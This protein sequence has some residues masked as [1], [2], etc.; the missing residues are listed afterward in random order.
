MAE[1][2]D[3]SAHV[4]RRDLTAQFRFV[5]TLARMRAAHQQAMRGHALRAQR[6]DARDEIFL[7][8][9]AALARG[10]RQYLLT[11]QLGVLLTPCR[12]PFCGRVITVRIGGGIDAA[13]DD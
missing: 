11:L 9:P 6:G 13:V 7:P 4:L 10:L 12:M 1:Q 5:M 3:V 2:R 8:L